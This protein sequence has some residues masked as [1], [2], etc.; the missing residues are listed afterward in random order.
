M[1]GDV[2][3]ARFSDSQF[4]ETIFLPLGGY[5][6]VSEEPIAPVGQPI[7]EERRELIWSTSSVSSRS[8]YLTM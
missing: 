6:I 7:H 5:K 1:T 8:T 4:D 2:F 3:T